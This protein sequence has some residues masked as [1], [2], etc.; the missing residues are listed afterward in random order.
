MW[1]VAPLGSYFTMLSVSLLVADLILFW[2]SR[3]VIPSVLTPSMAVMM[4]PW[5]K[6]PF[7]ALLPGVICARAVTT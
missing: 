6:L 3:W 1:C 7:T 5:A 2:A 4:S